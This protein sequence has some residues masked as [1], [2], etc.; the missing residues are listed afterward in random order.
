MYLI[1]TDSTWGCFRD[2]CGFWRHNFHYRENESSPFFNEPHSIRT[3]RPLITLQQRRGKRALFSSLWAEIF[4]SVESHIRKRKKNPGFFRQITFKMKAKWVSISPAGFENVS[5]GVFLAN[6]PFKLLHPIALEEMVGHLS[7]NT[8]WF[9]G[10]C[11]CTAAPTSLHLCEWL[12]RVNPAQNDDY[13]F[14]L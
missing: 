12:C 14:S 3:K 6:L 8:N 10:S 13:G 2:V 7:P 9:A 1:S 11:F 4:V 5:G